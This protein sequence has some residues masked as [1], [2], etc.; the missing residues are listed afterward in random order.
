MFRIQSADETAKSTDGPVRT[1]P[2]RELQQ[3]ND[4][5]GHAGQ[6]HRPRGCSEDGSKEEHDDLVD[7]L[8]E[9]VD[10]RTSED[11]D[12]DDDLGSM[13]ARLWR[14]LAE[15]AQAVTDRAAR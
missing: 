2:I 5:S 1:D 15:P 11:E 14:G 12:E 8:S 4:S 10:V 6:G 9:I 3:E 13:G 7:K